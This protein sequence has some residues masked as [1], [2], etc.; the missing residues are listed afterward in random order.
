L[1]LVEFMMGAGVSRRVGWHTAVDAWVSEEGRG[2]LFSTEDLR[3]WTSLRWQ[4][5][6][7]E[8]ALVAVDLV[9]ELW[10]CR[11]NPM[12]RADSLMATMRLNDAGNTNLCL[13][14]RECTRSW[15][16]QWMSILSLIKRWQSQVYFCWRSLRRSW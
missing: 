6:M 16:I 10:T 9:S 12:H 14:Q 4:H 15:I 13:C 2:P 8:W 1:A 11:Q 3:W 7:I 5:N